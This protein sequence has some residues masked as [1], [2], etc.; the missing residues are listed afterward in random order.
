MAYRL[1]AFSDVG[2]DEA[3]LKLVIGEHTNAVKPR[4]DRPSRRL[5]A[6][7]SMMASPVGSPVT[8]GGDDAV[9]TPSAVVGAEVV[10]PTFGPQI[11]MVSALTLRM[12][13]IEPEGQSGPAGLFESSIVSTS[14]LTRFVC[15]GVL[16]AVY[17]AAA[18]LGPSQGSLAVKA[19]AY[20]ERFAA[21]RG[22]VAVKIDTDGD[23]VADALR[24][25][26]VVQF[27]RG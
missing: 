15:L 12:L 16:H 4:L 21:E 3:L 23:G 9:I 14:A 27:V 24:R 26:N 19:A 13:G 8:R 5:P 18:A 20:R 22:R 2:L 10:V 25:L 11:R 1:G 6:R 7:S 17:S